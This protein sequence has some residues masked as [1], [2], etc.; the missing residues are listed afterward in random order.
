M[1]MIGNKEGD[2]SS[3]EEEEMWRHMGVEEVSEEEEER[4]RS[5]AGEMSEDEEE[6]KKQLRVWR[7]ET[8]L[9]V[10]CERTISVSFGRSNQ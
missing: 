2:Y 5:S 7:V 1:R 9:N 8:P 6:E 10:P 3:S 4:K